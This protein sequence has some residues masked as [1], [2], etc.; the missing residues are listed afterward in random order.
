M[1]IYENDSVKV[2][3]SPEMNY[4]FNKKTGFMALFGKTQDEDPDFSPYGPT[5]A[6][7]EIS[8]KCSKGC[9]FCYKSNTPK[10]ENMDLATFKKVLSKFNRTLTQVALGAGDIDANPDIWAIMEQ[11][12]ASGV[13]PNIT[14]NG[15]RMAPEL[16][17]KLASLCGAVAVS[18]YNDDE[19]FNAV[20]ELAKRGMKQTNIHALLS[21]E[22]YDKCFDLIDKAATDPRLSGLNAIVFLSLKPRGRGTSLTPL[23]DVAA[24]RKLVEYA[25]EKGISYGFDSCGANV[26]LEAMKDHPDYDRF[27]VLAEQCESWRFST[28]IDVQGRMFPCSFS[29]DGEGFDLTSD[30]I[31]SIDQIWN[32]DK[33]SNWR[34][35]LLGNCCNCP[36]YDIGPLKK[37]G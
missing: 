15:A 12:R 32:S 3:R 8:T 20:Q 1:N 11:C 30:E 26:F 34:C 16:F 6:D 2:L 23:R 21:R 9:K 19:C 29:A 18:H 35:K 4:L 31:E 10:G 33:V 25:T 24:Y 17:D 13:I 36:V 37:V 5:I 22:S 27:E 14:I 28:Y 7:I